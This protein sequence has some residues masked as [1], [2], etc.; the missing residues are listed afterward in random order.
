MV[1]CGRQAGQ[2]GEIGKLAQGD[3]HAEGARARLD[4][5]EG[6]ARWLGNGCGREIVAHQ[7]LGCDVRGDS[8]G[9]D[10]LAVG[11]FD[12]SR[13]ASRVNHARHGCVRPD[14]SATR[15]GCSC[16]RLS[17]RA[18]AADG[19]APDAGLAVHFAEAVMQQ[20]VGRARRVG[21]GKGSDNAV[22]GKGC[23]DVV[24]LEPAVEKCRRTL[25]EEI[26]QQ[27]L[28]VDRQPE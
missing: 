14:V 12:A 26:D 18:H 15:N 23:L 17:N 7:Q 16:H 22:E 1:R 25:G 8:A 5:G 21:T 9:V 24:V 3:I 20:H 4:A 2:A 6:C 27:P 28:R 13:A 19:V 11:E 10:D